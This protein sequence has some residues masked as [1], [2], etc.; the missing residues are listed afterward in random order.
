MIDDNKRRRNLLLLDL[1]HD[2]QQISAG[3]AVP[4]VPEVFKEKSHEA[5]R[6]VRFTSPAT[7]GF[8]SPLLS[9]SSLGES[10]PLGA[11]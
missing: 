7:R 4:C 10:K 9:L 5:A 2:I 1:G 11:G 3:P 8:L 6:R